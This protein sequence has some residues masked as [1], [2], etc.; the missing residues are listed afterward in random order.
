MFKI[1][2]I[3]FSLIF[4]SQMSY[5]EENRSAL[6]LATAEKIKHG[7]LSYAKKHNLNLSIAIYD[8]HGNLISFSCMDGAS[9]GVSEIARWK[10]KS[11]AIY[12]YPTSEMKEWNISSGPYIAPVAGGIPINSLTDTAIGAIGVSGADSLAD[13]A[14]AKA[15]ISSVR[16]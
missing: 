6:D 5:C 16:K 10:G 12:Q 7:C 8:S 1:G 2:P 4:I 3:I 13:V 9:V 14:C 11:A 15:G